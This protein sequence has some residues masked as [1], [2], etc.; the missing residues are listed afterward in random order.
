[1][2]FISA[3]PDTN[4][5]YNPHTASNTFGSLSPYSVKMDSYSSDSSGFGHSMPNKRE[6]A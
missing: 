5:A 4:A 6:D 3:C 2:R 1:M